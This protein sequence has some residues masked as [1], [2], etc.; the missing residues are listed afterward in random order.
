[1][2]ADPGFVLESST[3]SCAGEQ[4]YYDCMDSPDSLLRSPLY[5]SLAGKSVL[6]TGGSRRIGRSIG[7]AFA[8]AGARV[9]ITSQMP[10]Q[11]TTAT[12][13]EMQALGTQA[14]AVVCDLNDQRSIQSAIGATV[15]HTDGKLDILVNNAGSFETAPLETLAPEQWDRMF[16]VNTRA[17]LLVAQAAL[18][19]LRKSPHTGRIVNLG[20]LGGLRPWATHAH[21]CASKAALHMLTQTMAKAWAPAVA[22]NCIAPGMIVTGTEP[23]EAYAHFATKTPMGRNG[24]PEEVAELALFLGSCTPY[25]TGQILALDGGLGL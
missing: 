5:P 15:L 16:A 21:Y 23:D 1:M 2:P 14:Y 18:P 19:Y 4:R 13:G 6:I 22:V 9:V 12:L 8:A 11:Q 3:R 25:L 7:L 10:G 24:R 17:P 20:S